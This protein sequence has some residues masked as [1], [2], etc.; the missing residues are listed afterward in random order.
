MRYDADE[1][2]SNIKIEPITSKENIK[3]MRGRTT[4]GDNIKG[5]TFGKPFIHMSAKTGE[6]LRGPVPW[7]RKLWCKIKAMVK[8]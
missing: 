6:I 1:N 7:Y 4:V 8:R 2:V 5:Q 3:S